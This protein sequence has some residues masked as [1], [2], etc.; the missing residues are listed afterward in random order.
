MARGT[1]LVI[2]L[3]GFYTVVFSALIAAQN[4][5]IE[6]REARV[7]SQ[8]QK[9]EG[10]FREYTALKDDI[11]SKLER[12]FQGDMERWNA[13]LSK[14]DLSIK[15]FMDERSPKVMFKP[16]DGR[17]TDY[18]DDLIRDFCPRYYAVVRP[19]VES[20]LITEIKVE[21]HTSSEWKGGSD[22]STS[23]YSNLE[24]SQSRA[25]NVMESCLRSIESTAGSDYIPFRKKTTANGVAFSK[26]IV[27]PD[28]RENAN[29]S[30]RVEFKIVTSFDDNLKR[31]Q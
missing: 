7:V 24:L 20:S 14:D 30:R 19:M 28:G 22:E 15:F 5:D 27:G 31:L 17:Q 16:G 3:E 21:G 9:V 4:L 11:Y 8:E 23:Y 18:Y 10:A 6:S 25:K 12:E 29:A 1:G 13:S 26:V 2:V